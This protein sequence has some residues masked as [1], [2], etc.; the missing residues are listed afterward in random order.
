MNLLEVPVTTVRCIRRYVIS[1][2]TL[3]PKVR[4]IRRYVIS[5]GTLYP[6]VRYI[7]RYVISEGTLYPKV[8][9]TR[10]RY[11]EITLYIERYLPVYIIMFGPFILTDDGPRLNRKAS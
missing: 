4:Y 10:V 11:N 5:A 7:R 3:Y 1:E 9:N 2:G 6:K 8:R